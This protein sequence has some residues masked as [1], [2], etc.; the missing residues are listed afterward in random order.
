MATTCDCGT[1]YLWPC[2]SDCD[3]SRP[4]VERC[5]ACQV[6]DDDWAAAAAIATAVGGIVVLGQLH[7][8]VARGRRGRW[9]PAV[10]APTVSG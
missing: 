1:G 2:A 8:H 10:Y 6:F 5:D 3:D 7:D 4:Y 9:Q